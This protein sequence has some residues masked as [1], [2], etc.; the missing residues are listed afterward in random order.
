M[1]DPEPPVVPIGICNLIQETM[2]S[3]WGRL[4][5]VLIK[6]FKDFQLAEDALQDAFETALVNWSQHGVPASPAG[7]LMQTAKRKA[8]DRLRRSAN[9]Q[10]KQKEYQIMT[11]PGNGINDTEIIPDERLRLIFTCCHPALNEN[12]RLALT[13][14]SVGGLT[15]DEVARAF[16]V[17]ETTMAQRLVRAKQKI[18]K[19]AI[20]YKI[21]E[22]DD[23][24]DRLTSVLGVLYL[25]FNEGYA[26]TKGDSQIRQNL[27]EEAIWLVRLM[28]ELKPDEPEIEGLLALML[29]NYS[30]S[31]ARL[32]DGGK[33]ISL[34]KQNRSLWDRSL[35]NEGL[36]LVQQAMKRQKIGPYQLQAA[37]SAIHTEAKT[38]EDTGWKE[39]FFL[40]QKL[41]TIT[42]NPVVKLNQV[43]A[44]SYICDA[45]TALSMLEDIEEPLC[46]YQPYYAAKSDLLRRAGRIDE[47][48]AA[49][50]TAISLTHTEA[51]KEYL[52][53]C[54]DTLL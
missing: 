26:A 52:M 6:Q 13:L 41:F 17:T 3:Q 44:L 46:S 14:R 21:P 30:R 22:E 18:S 38:Y 42:K 9:F 12:A 4:L 45:E 31:P 19:A 34:E 51:E 11:E 39:I 43:V 50:K 5:S 40:Y 32:E 7:W 33:F 10:E 35:I 27:C 54:L 23:F 28:T 16:L 29:L 47:A 53:E 1:V 15:T 25:I 36:E 20:P 48:K 8:I 37:I 49:Y 24:H 2:R